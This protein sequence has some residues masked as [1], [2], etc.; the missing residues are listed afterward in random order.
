ML[1]W[2]LDF[3]VMNDDLIVIYTDASSVGLGF[4]FPE[5]CF[6]CQCELP[7]SPPTDIIFYFKELA[8][9]SAIHL[10]VDIED[11]P[12]RLLVYTDNTNTVALFNSL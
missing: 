2:P 9:C 12:S 8:V 7:H 6:T 11:H 1:Y 3:L 10:L 4:W 5:D